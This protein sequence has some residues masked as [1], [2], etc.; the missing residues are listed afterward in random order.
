MGVFLATESLEEALAG[1]SMV[2]GVNWGVFWQSFAAAAE[3][4]FSGCEFGAKSKGTRS[5]C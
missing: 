3:G 2:G 5:A 1:I 4:G